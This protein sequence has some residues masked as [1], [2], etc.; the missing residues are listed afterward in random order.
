MKYTLTITDMNDEEFARVAN[1]FNITPCVEVSKNDIV[2][3]DE[4]IV[5]VEEPVLHGP[6]YDKNGLPW[7]ERIHS[8]NHKM[9]DKGVW[10]R[11]RGITDMEFERV[12]NELLGVQAPVTPTAPV[13]PVTPTAPVAPVVSEPIAPVAPVQPQVMAPTP[14]VTPEIYA[15]QVTQPV[16]P[17]TPVAPTAQ[18]DATALFKTM[19][20]KV[21]AGMAA[22]AV[23]AND[24][25]DLITAV[26]TQFGTQYQ[27]LAAINDNVVA[28]QFVINDLVSKGL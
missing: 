7:D 4:P 2:L 13:A 20:D 9:T 25:R 24:V 16:A 27:T 1:A 22:G 26:N 17:V 23:K 12:K 8:S 5:P 19:F 14:L 21:K 15:P 11:R 10:Q 6:A 3:T 18:P 28:L